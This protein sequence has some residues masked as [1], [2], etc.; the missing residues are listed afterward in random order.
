MKRISTTY[1]ILGRLSSITWESEL[2]IG[3]PGQQITATFLYRDGFD[4]PPPAS[5]LLAEQD[6]K[7]LPDEELCSASLDFLGMTCDPDTDLSLAA[8]RCG[9]DPT[10]GRWLLLEPSTFDAD[11]A[12]LDP[13]I[14]QPQ[15]QQQQ[16][17]AANTDSPAHPEEHIP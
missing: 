8:H 4:E 10:P 5:Y 7:C 16:T 3:P 1:D 14:D 17:D 9:P 15:A 12:N 6:C 11:A 2:G 13:C